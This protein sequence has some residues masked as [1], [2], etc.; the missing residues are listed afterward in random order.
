MGEK[1]LYQR[2]LDERVIDLQTILLTEGIHG[3]LGE[4]D[5]W[6][7]QNDLIDHK[8]LEELRDRTKYG[9]KLWS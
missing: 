3:L 5:V 7:F 9:V 4:Y 2:F 1:D 8:H 6:L